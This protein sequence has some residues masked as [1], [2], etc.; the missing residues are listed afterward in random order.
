[1]QIDA[2][3]GA[4]IE[5]KVFVPFSLSMTFRQQLH[6]LCERARVTPTAV[7]FTLFATVVQQKFDTQS[8]QWT[9]TV[10]AL[11]SPT[12]ISTPLIV[13]ANFEGLLTQFQ[14]L[15]S[16]SNTYPQ[17]L[18]YQ[19]ADYCLTLEVQ[20][21]DGMLQPYLG[22]HLNKLNREQVLQILEQYRATLSTY[23]ASRPTI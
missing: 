12:P 19:Q 9:F 20:Q 2:M 6:K 4:N 22:Y 3:S 13:A 8:A 23:T 1:M 7:L 17:L 15:L 21:F 14:Q 10:P 18:T 5:C 16:A 11:P